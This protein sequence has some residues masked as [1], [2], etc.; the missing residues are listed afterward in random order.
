VW[1]DD[2]EMSRQPAF[3]SAFSWLSELVDVIG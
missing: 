2:D 3:R 1:R